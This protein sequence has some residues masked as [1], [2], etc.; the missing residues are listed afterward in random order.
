M[1]VK[2]SSSMAVRENLCLHGGE[3]VSNFHGFNETFSGD[4][5][6]TCYGN[7]RDESKLL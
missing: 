1:M 7:E 3:G 2:G 4:V 5:G 6:Y